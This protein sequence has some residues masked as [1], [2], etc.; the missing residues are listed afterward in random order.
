[1]FV[2][3]LIFG[4]VLGVA[5]RSFWIGLFAFALPYAIFTLWVASLPS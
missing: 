5:A 3:P 4:I 2:F 1:M